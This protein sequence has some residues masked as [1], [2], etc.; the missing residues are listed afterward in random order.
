MN[1]EAFDKAYANLNKEQKEAVDTIEGPVMVNAGPGTGKTQIL[2]LRIANILSKTDTK[3]EQILALTF[4]NAGSFTMR[5]RLATYIGDLSYRVN[6]FTFHA[7][8]EHVIKNN[9]T[10]FPQFEYAQVIDDLQKVKIVESIIDSSD[11]V[12]LVTAHDDYM[13]VR[14]IVRAINS[15]KKEGFTPEEFRGEIPKWK[16]ELYGDENL[17]YKR[18][19]REFNAGDIKPVEEQ[20]IT[21]RIEQ[22]YE[23]VEAYAKYQEEL[24]RLRLYD[25]SDMILTVLAKLRSDENFAFD[26]QEQY[27]YILVDEH[28]DTNTGQNELIELLT[29]A[30]HLDRHPNIFTVGDEKQ[31]IYR[32][33]GASEETFRHFNTLY[34][35]IQH[36]ALKENYRSVQNIL[37]AS[38]A[39]ITNSIPDAVELHAN[40]TE[41]MPITIGEFS[42]YKFELLHIGEDIKKK[43][44]AGVS[45]EEIAILYRANKHLGDV[46]QVLAHFGVPFSVYSKDS[47]FEDVDIS[48]IITLLRIVLDPLD[49]ESLAKSLFVQFVGISG[50]DAIKILNA[51]GKYAREGK[52]LF[53]ILSSSQI[54]ADLHIEN[55]ASIVA[56]AEKINAAIT[57]SR[58]EHILEFLKNFLRDI[59]YLPYM[60]QSDL[61]R[62]KM[63]KLDKLFDEIKR[64]NAKGTFALGDFIKLVDSYHAYHLDIESGSTEYEAGVQLMTAHGSKGKEFEHVYI[65]NT[66]RSN[67]EKSRSFGGITLP[68]KDYK[69]DEHDERRLFYVAMTRAKK[70]LSITYS[71]SD[72]EGREQEKSQ[73]ITELPTECTTTLDTEAFEKSHLTDLT[74]FLMPFQSER[75]IYEPA[76]IKDL[77]MKKGLTATG[78][79]NYLNCPIKYFYRNLVQIPSGYSAHMQYG[80]EVH[81]AL[82]KFFFE[83]KKN[84]EIGTVERLIELFDII[85]AY[86][87]LHESDKRKYLKRGREALTAWYQNRIGDM[88]FNVQTEQRIYKDF[89]LSSGEILKLNGIIDKIEFL[90]SELE[91]PINIVDYKTGKAYS[92]KNKDQKADLARQLTFYHILLE[93]YREGAYRINETRLD[94]IEPND[95]GVSELQTL[96][97]TEEEIAQV[98]QTIDVTSHA[99]MSGEFLMH[100]CQKKDCEWCA[101]HAS[102]QRK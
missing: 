29:S 73:F 45:P 40:K 23:I 83:A 12:H 89:M 6:I 15:I 98:R 21:K 26:L 56:F 96:A 71:K 33:Q 74:F 37:S 102:V 42:N 68:I 86:S 36:I 97:V 61:S 60:L 5:E 27:Q 93:G 39:S 43:L 28:Q 52:R 3:P 18:K 46:K 4:T 55:A 24:K 30:E 99:I 69:G 31:S 1:S 66:T 76:F 17:F 9:T 101:L 8:C 81:C 72:W 19:Y 49:E 95:R 34:D 32:F 88:K 65:I 77:F 38:H 87:S 48:N 80:N 51:R 79:N 82:E 62:D 94:F 85:M 44:D 14:D 20:K 63:L 41:N 91:G 58:N 70:E 7:F 16:E 78:L 25:F 2:T 13:K 11:F 84:G 90:E 59:G 92:K 75:T 10:Y 54:L 22:A 100:G 67:W 50:Y 47:V 35:D 53:D 57:A 64:Q